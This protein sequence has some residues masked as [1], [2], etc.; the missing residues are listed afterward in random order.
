M[1]DVPFGVNAKNMLKRIAAALILVAAVSF[2]AFFLV[3][4]KS[5]RS[6]NRDFIAYWAAGQCLVRGQNP[7]DAATVFALQKSVGLQQRKPQ[8]M[9][10]PP[11]ALI[12]T[13]PLGLMDA[14]P[15]ILLWSLAIIASIVISIRLIWILHGRRSDRLHLI[16]YTFAPV[17]MCVPTGQTSAFILLGMALFLYWHERRPLLAGAAL[18]LCALKPHLFFPFW[19]VLLVWSLNRKA[20]RVVLGAV[21]GVVIPLAVVTCFDPLL[22]SHYASMLRGQELD[23]GFV[24]NPSVFLR[25]LISPGSLWLQYLPTLIAC[26][27]VLWYFRRHRSGW[28]WHTHGVLLA[29]VSIWVAPYSWFTDEAALLPAILQAI[30]TRADRGKS[31]L[32][33]GILNGIAVLEVAADVTMPSGGYAWTATAW[34]L[35]YLSGRPTSG[36]EGPAS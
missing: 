12:L 3:R 16:G 28:S 8:I 26:L 6:T 9:R 17:L 33:F 36:K 1:T 21:L 34:L 5:G 4:D 27:W 18:A 19:L 31:L 23:T 15:A 11:S 2:L 14:K 10:N 29:L 25:G 20:H 35:W 7:Y 13:L 22:L 32:P 24:P 30:Y